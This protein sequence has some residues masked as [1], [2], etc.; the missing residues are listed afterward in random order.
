MH[1]GHYVSYYVS[2]CSWRTAA[3]SALLGHFL[4]L[5][6]SHVPFPPSRYIPN[7]DDSPKYIDLYFLESPKPVLEILRIP[8]CFHFIAENI[9][10][11]E[12]YFLWTAAERCES[13]SMFSAIGVQALHHGAVKQR[14]YVGI[15]PR[16]DLDGT[17]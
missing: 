10:G 6:L 1:E 7:K 14:P 4:L 12:I 17:A 8:H 2:S 16:L 5:Q 9:P 13:V 11:G 3:L 15:K